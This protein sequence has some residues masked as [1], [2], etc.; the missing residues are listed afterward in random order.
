MIKLHGIV[1]ALML[2]SSRLVTCSYCCFSEYVPIG[3]RF[4]N[5]I[6]QALLVLFEK[7][8]PMVSMMALCKLD[9]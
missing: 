7:H 2:M 1:T 4:S 6:L 9:W 5:T 3:P 8:P